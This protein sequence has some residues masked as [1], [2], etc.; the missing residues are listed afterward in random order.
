MNGELM[1]SRT[2][3]LLGVISLVTLSIYGPLRAS[4]IFHSQ[5]TA[6]SVDDDMPLEPAPDFEL[7]SVDGNTVKLS[8]FRGKVAVLNTVVV[9]DFD[10]HAM[11]LCRHVEQYF[12]ALEETKVHLKAVGVPESLVTMVRSSS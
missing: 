5:V 11:W 7:K 2:F 8:D 4:R 1:K 6:S 3:I 12:V 10:V 9:T